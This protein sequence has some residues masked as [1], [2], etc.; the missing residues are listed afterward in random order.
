M[1]HLNGT[2]RAQLN[3]FPFAMEEMVDQ[4]NPVRVI[5]LFAS[6]FDFVKLGFNHSVAAQ[7]GRPPYLPADLMKLYLYGYLNRIR[8]SRKLEKECVRNI[9]LIW[10]LKGLRPSF[11]TIAGFRSEHSV[12]I[13]NFFRQFVSLLRG[14]DLVE[15]KLI[16]IDGSK[17]RAVN[18]R[19]NNFNEKK[20]ERNLV[21]IDEKINSYL[22]QLDA[23]DKSE[24]GDR[25]L[26]VEKIKSQIETQ[27]QRR[28]KYEALR[29]ELKQTSEEQI[30]TTDKDARSMPINHHRIEVSYN[31]QTAVDS[32][33]CL[34]V[35]YENT[36]VNDKKA[37]VSVAVETKNI[38]Q[39]DSIEVLADKGYHNGEQIDTCTK[40]NIVTY[41]ASPD[42]PRSNEIPTPA[43]HGD[44]F[45]YDVQRD[46]YTCPQKQTLTT[47]GKW[48]KKANGFKYENDVKHYKTR[49]CKTCP[50]KSL[51]T[52][53]KNGRLIERSQ[54]AM[55]VEANAKRVSTEKE[56]YSLRQQ[57][58]EHPFGTIKRQWG[59]DHVLMKGKQ[60]NEAEFGLIFSAYNLRRILSILGIPEL[61]MRL[62][63]AFLN[64]LSLWR[65]I[66]HTIRQIF[67]SQYRSPLPA[68][69]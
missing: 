32:K 57:I 54:Y 21:Y 66:H 58:V 68:Q 59:F 42:I 1:S 17:F 65:W 6:R 40:N 4:D 63:G 45:I 8:S 61:K 39:K 53:N 5:D 49:A 67:S 18:A 13:K 22:T 15:G 44:K 3:M 26:D 38:L 19:K 30:S 12:Q 34:I 14:W 10:L 47:N 50:A 31:A 20:I 24:H 52:R 23:E 64:F 9:E 7:E 33:H 29:N 36:N 37:L 43:Y 46:V 16:A 62:R 48:Y 51:C 11:R 27:Q 25:K 56:K 2:D 35:N 69:L 41:V 60:K 28:K 55:T